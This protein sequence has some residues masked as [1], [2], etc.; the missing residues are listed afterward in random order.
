MREAFDFAEGFVAAGEPRAAEGSED[1]LLQWTARLR[2][3]TPEAGVGAPGGGRL[4]SDG[5]QTPR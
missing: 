4:G 1:R 2:R 3:K 5:D